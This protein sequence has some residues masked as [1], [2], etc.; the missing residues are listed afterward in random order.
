MPE[1]KE[2]TK[3]P[4]METY[5]TSD[6]S[7]ATERGKYVPAGTKVEYLGHL[8]GAAI[9]VRMADGSVEIMHPACFKEL[10]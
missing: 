8:P 4:G 2:T 9:R 1:T 5:M 3:G 7:G 6:R 10:R